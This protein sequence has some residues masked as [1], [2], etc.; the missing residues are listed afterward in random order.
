MTTDAEFLAQLQER[1]RTT[2]TQ[3]AAMRLAGLR[4]EAAS[5]EGFRRSLWACIAE[6]SSRVRSQRPEKPQPPGRAA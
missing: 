1:H 6:L 5:L 4:Q 2:E 3:I